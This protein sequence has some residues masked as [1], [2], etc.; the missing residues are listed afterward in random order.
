MRMAPSNVC[1][2][3]GQRT[4]I[5]SLAWCLTVLMAPAA[6]AQDRRLEIEYT[7]KVADIP[8]QLFHVTTDIR[9]INQPALE[10]SLPVWSP[11]WY[12]IENYAKNIY[13]FRVIIPGGRELRPALVRKQ[14]WRID[15]KGISRIT[16]EFD[17]HAA[18]LSANQARI[19]PD[20]AF[21]TGT[22]LEDRQRTR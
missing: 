21:F 17:Y 18:I 7:V 14:T 2:L 5:W 8:G 16:V 11:G 10:L 19:A 4:L 22:Q 12:V 9:N 13:R 20:Y 3:T 1:L 15:T 6:A